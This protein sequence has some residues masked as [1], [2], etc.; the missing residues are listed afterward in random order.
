MGLPATPG[1]V[2][3]AIERGWHR[4]G[5]VLMRELVFRDF[6]EA[7][8][9]VAALGRGAVDYS[10]LPDVTISAGHVALI[11]GNPRHAGL[12]RAEIRLVDKASRVIE[13]H[14]SDAAAPAPQATVRPGEWNPVRWP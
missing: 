1:D 3:S 13:R 14:F 4:H 10:R 2:D 8:D 6:G 5:D 12:T 7:L 11:V 9:F